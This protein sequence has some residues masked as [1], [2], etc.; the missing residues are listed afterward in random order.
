MTATTIDDEIRDAWP[1]VRTELGAR[2]I[3]TTGP[4]SDPATT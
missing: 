3:G 1:R 4:F 2:R